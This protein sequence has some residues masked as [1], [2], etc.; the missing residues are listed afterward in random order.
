MRLE[1]GLR[2]FLLDA[3]AIQAQVAQRIYGVIREPNSPLPSVNIQRSHT[4]RQELFCGVS[5]LVSADLTI[6]SYGI[7]GDQAWALAE[8]LKLLFRN[9]SGEVGDTVVKKVFLT[10]EFPLTDPDPGVFR[11]VQLYNFWYL[12]D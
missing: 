2:T 8:A 10:N 12:E 1:T 9:F 3:P 6:D 4:A 7:D 11:I 5:P